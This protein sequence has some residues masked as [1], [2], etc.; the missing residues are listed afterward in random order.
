[1]IDPREVHVWRVELDSVPHRLDAVLARAERARAERFRDTTR[2]RAFAA[3]HAAL[4]TILAAYTDARPERLS[5]TSDA[6]GKPRLADHPTLHFSLARSR[7]LAL[8]AVANREVGVDVEAMRHRTD[9]LEGAT[10][11]LPPP[12]AARLAA[13]PPAERPRAFY[14]AWT[15]LEARVKCSGRGLS[16]GGYRD[17]HDGIRARA[18]GVPEGYAGAIAAAGDDWHARSFDWTPRVSPLAW[19]GPGV[20][21]ESGGS[22]RIRT[23]EPEAPCPR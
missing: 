20:A 10:R 19:P 12:A 18:V 16:A 1:V 14:A 3:A 15:A 2:G 23:R 6:L 17:G 21:D 4:R 7:G 8:V 22:A 5:V 13:L 9:V 11:A